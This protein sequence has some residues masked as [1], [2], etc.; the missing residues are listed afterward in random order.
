L[1]RGKFACRRDEI[2][3]DEVVVLLGSLKRGEEGRGKVLKRK[4]ERN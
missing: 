1:D 2:E 4:I 3:V